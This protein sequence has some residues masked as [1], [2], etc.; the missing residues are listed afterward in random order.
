MELA[1]VVG[2][3]WATQKAESMKGYKLLITE[4]IGA[5]STDGNRK[6]IIAADTLGAGMGENVL[7]VK[8]SSAR[9]GDI[10]GVAPIDATIIAI[11]DE[12]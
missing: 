12:K 2:Q 8:G 5:Q 7:I 4:L 11:L 3:I 10:T 6:R 9:A 1:K